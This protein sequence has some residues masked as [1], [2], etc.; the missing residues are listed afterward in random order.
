MI[1]KIILT[2]VCLFILFASNLVFAQEMQVNCDSAMT[3]LEMNTCAKQGY[4][5]AQLKLDSIFS[6]LQNLIKEQ[7]QYYQDENQLNG[8]NLITLFNDSQEQW[9]KFRESAAGFNSAIYQGGSI[10]PLIYYSVMQSITEDRIKQ[11]EDLYQE[12]DN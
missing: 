2:K 4:E 10:Q 9:L 1:N 12:M 6:K 11:L 3:Q 7:Q 8:K 5:K